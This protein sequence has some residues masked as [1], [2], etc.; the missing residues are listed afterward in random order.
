MA[1]DS[2]AGLALLMAA[3]L[4][5]VVV[6]DTLP[7]QLRS[8]GLTALAGLW[9]GITR[10]PAD[11]SQ[12]GARTAI[13]AERVKQVAEGITRLP[14]D[15][16]PHP[17]HKKLLDNRLAMGLGKTPIDWGTAEAFARVGA[18]AHATCEPK[19]DLLEALLIASLPKKEESPC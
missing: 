13:S 17:K 15:F 14:G 19:P 18:P 8:A 12:W 10:A 11:L 2:R 4:L 9:R 6:V 1:L 7:L 5:I 16:T 3:A